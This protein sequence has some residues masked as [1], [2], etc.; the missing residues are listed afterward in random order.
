MVR[1]LTYTPEE[2]LRDNIRIDQL[3]QYL[4]S[5]NSLVWIDLE[6]PSNKEFSIL[7][8]IF[9]FHPLAI[10][11]CVSKFH[12]P[13]IDDYENYL[14]L[15]WHSLIDNE[16]TARLET[17]EVDIFIGPNYLV[18]LHAEKISEIDNLYNSVLKHADL[19]KT[20]VDILLHTLLD[21]VTDKYFP[22]LDRISDKID[23][24]ED[25]MFSEPTRED[26][27]DLFVIK[28]QMLTVRKIIAPEREVINA[29]ARYNTHII[30]SKHI[31]YFQ[32][33][34]DH[35]IRLTD[36]VDTSRDLTAGA[37]D[38]YLTSISNKLNEIMKRLTIVASIFMPLTLISSIYGMNFKFMPELNLRYSYFVVLII[39]AII[40][41]WMTLYFK[42]KKWW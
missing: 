20:G 12:L 30:R 21:D 23:L 5:K 42:K 8:D 26:L 27:R 25:K 29:L 31:I 11:D 10:E 6:E 35:L 34:Y 17:A 41:I 37:M 24:L 13:K 40:A 19:L 18:T 14:F 9:N 22:L 28:H 33:I 38:I 36:L 2:Q 39:M 4:E 16:K 3:K 7:K 32:D 15:I 1:L